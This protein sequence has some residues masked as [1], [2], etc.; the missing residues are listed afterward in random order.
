[1]V[2]GVC[3]LVVVHHMFLLLL[4][5]VCVRACVRACMRACVRACV[6]VC[7]CVSCMCFV[8]SGRTANLSAY[9]D[10]L[11]RFCNHVMA[12]TPPGVV[13]IRSAGCNAWSIPTAHVQMSTLRRTYVEQVS[14]FALWPLNPLP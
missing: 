12:M 14:I 9:E 10:Y 8:Y 4:D 11:S 2:S 6:C 3:R 13:I 7:L 1:M 5:C